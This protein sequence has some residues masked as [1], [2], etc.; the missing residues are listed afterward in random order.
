M[1]HP[2]RFPRSLDIGSN[3]RDLSWT[4]AAWIRA[5]A[6]SEGVVL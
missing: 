4:D 3:T 2:S 6:A 5:I 1:N